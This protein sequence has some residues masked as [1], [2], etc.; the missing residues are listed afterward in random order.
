[1]VHAHRECE[2]ALEL[3]HNKNLVYSEDTHLPGNT[4]GKNSAST[5][6]K[7]SDETLKYLINKKEEKHKM[8]RESS[9]ALIKLS[10]SHTH[11][12]TTP[13]NPSF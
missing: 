5:T 9:I 1:V 2:P 4:V 8:K 3:G 6:K 10:L 12:H 13:Q 11:K 7:Q